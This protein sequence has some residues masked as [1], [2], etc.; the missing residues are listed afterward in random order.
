MSTCS[1]VGVIERSINTLIYT[2]GSICVIWFIYHFVRK[3]KQ[4]KQLVSNKCLYCM[5]LTYGVINAILF[6]ASA[7]SSES[8]C[9][10]DADVYAK[11]HL[12]ARAFYMLQWLLLIWLWFYRLYFI[13]KGTSFAL[14]RRSIIIISCTYILWIIVAINSSI[15]YYFNVN[16]KILVFMMGIAMMLVLSLVVG[17]V[18]IFAHKLYTVYRNKTAGNTKSMISII[19]KMFLLTLSSIIFFIVYVIVAMFYVQFDSIHLIFI[20]GIVMAVHVIIN[21]FSIMLGLK[22]FGPYYVKICGRFDRQCTVCFTK[23]VA[24]NA[25]IQ[26]AQNQ[27]HST[28]SNSASPSSAANVSK[29][30][31]TAKDEITSSTKTDAAPVASI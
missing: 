2:I 30:Q 25:G 22:C 13:F 5:I 15:C 26:L 4:E 21:V 16:P 9:F 14:S 23:M 27:M 1:V 17:L 7:V 24:L 3:A 28:L 11:L 18:W 31:E 6:M 29:S 12:V 8:Y 19:T 10:V 20:H